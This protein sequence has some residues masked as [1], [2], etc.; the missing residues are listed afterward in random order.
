MLA[1]FLEDFQGMTHV[2]EMRCLYVFDF[3]FKSALLQLWPCQDG[4]NGFFLHG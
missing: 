4:Q 2:V 1:V 3:L